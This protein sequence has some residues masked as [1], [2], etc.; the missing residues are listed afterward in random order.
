MNIVTRSFYLRDTPLVAHDLLGKK[1]VRRIGD[2]KL[3][4]IISE[5]EA[6]RSDDPASHA[7]TGR[8][9]RNKSLFGPPGHAY[10]YLSYGLHYCLNIV[11]YDKQNAVA[12]G[13][14]IRAII[15]I[16]GFGTMNEKTA[17][18]FAKGPGLV[19][20]AFSITKADD[21]VDLTNPASNLVVA[22]GDQPIV[23]AMIV[24]TPRIG[25]SKA[26]DVL[27]RFALT[28]EAEQG[29]ML[30]QSKHHHEAPSYQN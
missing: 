7:F 15:P 11:S 8:S 24:V 18:R 13:C 6:Y 12:G 14:L 27:W 21:G 30:H 22:A 2:K 5:V 1:L 19:G 17:L 4:G 10:V 23:D 28:P 29:I 16:E 20:R 3:V 9:Q 26:K 25:I